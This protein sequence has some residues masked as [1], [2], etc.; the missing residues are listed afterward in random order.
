M[1]NRFKRIISLG[2][3][4]AAVQPSG[5]GAYSDIS[6]LFNSRA[7][8][9]SG[10][11][12]LW[13]AALLLI[14]LGT[15]VTAFGQA[16]FGSISGTVRDAS[17]AVIPSASVTVTD[18]QK[19][20]AQTVTADASGFY[21]VERLTPDTYNVRGSASGFTPSE[22]DGITV[23]AN[24]EPK[25]DLALKIGATQQTV[26]VN[27][28][29]A[30]LQTN[31]AQV[32]DRIPSQT[33][34]DVPSAT[35]NFAQFQQLTAG[36]STS[37]S[38]NAL[39]QNPQGSPY[40]SI[41]GQN[42]GTQGWTI[43]GTDDR[44]PVL[45]IIVVNPTLDSVQDLQ[46]LTQNYDAEFG[47]GVGG[48]VT[49]ET[50]SGGNRVH[51]DVFFYRHSDAQEAKNPFTQF[52][53]SPATGKFIPSTVF[54]Q[55]G[56][57]I[58]GPIIKNRTFFFTDY[59]GTRSK[60]GQSLILS[61][62]TNLVRSTCLTAS[63]GTCNLSEYLAG[64]VRQVYDPTTRAAYTGNIIP[65]ANIASQAV[66]LLS[67]LPAP[68]VAGAGIANNYV[69]AGFGPN[70]GDAADLRI[71][72]QTTA[73]L[74]SFARY[75][76]VLFKLSGQNVFGAAGGPGLGAGN[77]AGTD[78]VQNQNLSSGF[79]YA[80]NNTWETDFR[81]GLVKYA[82]NQNQNSAG[83][84]PASGFGIPGLNT[85]SS[86]T[87]GLPD[88][89]F[90][91]STLTNLGADISYN[92]TQICNCPLKQSEQEFEFVNNWSK[93][94]G[95]HT[96][97]FGGDLRYA[98]NI[99]NPSDTNPAG[100]LN[101]AQTTTANAAGSGGL[102]LA[103]ALLGQVSTFSRYVLFNPTVVTAQKRFA[104]FAQDSWKITPK[105]SLNYGVRWDMTF[106]ETV[107]GAGNGGLSNINTGFEQVAGVGPFGS[108][109]G[110]QMDYTNFAPRV[111]AAYQVREN[112]VVRGGFATVY[113]SEGFYGTL[114]GTNLV[115][116]SPTLILQS[117]SPA[118]STGSVFSL[119]T[120]PVA[121]APPVVSSGGVY[122]LANGTSFT[123]RPTKI[124]L[125]KVD[126][127]TLAIQQAYRDTTF[128]IAY[129]GNYAERAYPGTTDGFNINIPHLPTTPAD[130]ANQAA[131]RPLF[132]K[133][134]NNGVLCCN[135]TVSSAAPAATENYNGL[136]TKVVQKFH[137]NATLQANYTWSKAMNFADPYF[138]WDQS[139]NHS[140]NDLNRTNVFNLFGS[141]E[142]PFGKGKAFLNNGGA[143][144]YIVGGW[145][146]SGDSTWMSGLPFT[147]TYAE[148]ASDQD[149]DTSGID[150]RPNGSASGFAVGG[151]GLN[152]TIHSVSYFTPV[153][154]LAS[155]GSSSGPFQR[156]AFGTFG[157]IGRNS[158]VGP[159]E[160]LADA[161]LIK[162]FALPEHLDG[163]FQF[164]AFNV[165][166]HP[167]LAV[168]ANKCIDCTT[169]TPGQITSLDPNI[170]M[171]QLQF[172][173]RIEF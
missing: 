114:F 32:S 133:F 33:L 36:T 67:I 144:N 11:A 82:V 20:I 145:R 141:Y 117:L 162:H 40:Y 136:Q 72:D 69:A 122:P 76:Y 80:L 90:T 134:D 128:E 5:C 44:D 24:S 85:G 28:A 97:R 152:S 16:V 63:S 125:P 132:N 46:V 84:N 12:V 18:V 14:S 103:T 154:P 26:E 29:P 151:R 38:S 150:C 64:G 21:R 159:N 23:A 77:F 35:R 48:M 58:S 66:N 79:D 121:Q 170:G 127:W 120:G 131:R 137:N 6:K 105:L 52:Q 123:I 59:Q 113:D 34:Q 55:F 119:A 169:G 65:K 173:F 37:P 86:Y 25:I 74:H 31:N 107:A 101:F 96:I 88:F 111:G 2:H 140:R 99:R 126:Q 39:A 8:R 30:L 89:L 3:S 142:L 110:A 68:N 165:F 51:G 168:P 41:N 106:P 118:S 100:V 129:V 83:K 157:N 47:G 61:V 27:A 56:G 158:L 161:S 50:K 148:C 17:G 10:L 149:V 102:D 19:G 60:S 138:V 93:T 155:S 1:L 87:S 167:A 124:Q 70:N 160:F 75:S 43:D 45:G 53:P 71:D 78:K 130:L 98:L 91:N 95:K 143:L 153:A 108:N 172:A 13:T 22:T 166:N 147:P 9:E 49:A 171:R 62:P 109:A 115:R 7:I 139:V 81:F 94:A 156:P 92:G 135:T 146:L 163:Q 164:Q 15:E 54:S 112:T 57:S 116:N 104:I 73:R 4:S 42:F